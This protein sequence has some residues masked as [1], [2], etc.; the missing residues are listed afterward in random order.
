MLL[1][2]E[3]SGYPGGR[4]FQQEEGGSLTSIFLASVPENLVSEIMASGILVSKDR[5]DGK[6]LIFNKRIY[7]FH[8]FLTF[9]L[10]LSISCYCDVKIKCLM[11]PSFT[12]SE[13]QIL[14]CA[15]FVQRKNSKQGW[16]Q[17][18]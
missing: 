8:Y 4:R 14:F 6:L 18:E 9:L 2:E 17:R 11:F 5:V 12:S 10:H 15:L 3:S 7:I 13:Y 1:S 16:E